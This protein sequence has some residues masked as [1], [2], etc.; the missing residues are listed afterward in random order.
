MASWYSNPA[1]LSG[2]PEQKEVV[3]SSKEGKFTINK[4]S[5]ID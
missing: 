5:I 4:G 3:I 1:L 2:F